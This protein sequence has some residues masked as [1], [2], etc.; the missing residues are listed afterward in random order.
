MAFIDR[1]SPWSGVDVND[2]IESGIIDRSDPNVSSIIPDTTREYCWILPL[3][4]PIS[5]DH[6]PSSAESNFILSTLFMLSD[7][8]PDVLY[9]EIKLLPL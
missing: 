2:D 9:P 1:I 7:S 4:F 3:E 8:P 5:I 6:I